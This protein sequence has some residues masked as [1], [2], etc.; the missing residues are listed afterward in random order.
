MDINKF[1]LSNRISGKFP[2]IEL[3]DMEIE[4]KKHN[5]IISDKLDSE[6]KG[7]LSRNEQV[8]ILLNRRGYSPF[9]SCTN[10]GYVYKCPNCDISLIYHKSSK[11]YSCHYCGY[12]IVRSEVCPNCHEDGIKD[13]IM[14][15]INRFTNYSK[16]LLSVVL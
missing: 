8:M 6:I 13:L 1:N 12:R 14:V 11:N 7:A 3:V 9:L 5:Y 15:D 4:A 16:E 10:C 2:N